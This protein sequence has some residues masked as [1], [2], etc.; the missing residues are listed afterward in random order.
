MTGVIKS[1]VEDRAFGFIRTEQ[2]HELFFHKDDY[3]GFW[4]DLVAKFNEN[5]NS[6]TVQFNEVPGKKGARASNVELI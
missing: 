2:G 1:I 5:P 6:L 3:L 4:N